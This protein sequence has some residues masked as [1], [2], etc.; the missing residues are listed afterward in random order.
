MD[1]VVRAACGAVRGVAR[2]GYCTF[3][4]IPYAAPLVGARR[5]RSPAPPQ[6]WDGVR[7]ARRFGS[8]VPQPVLWH[9]GDDPECLTVNV[10][11]PDVGTSGMPVMV[12]LH[13][14][15]CMGGTAATPDFDGAAF[16]AAGIVLV[17]VNYR[18]GYEG[19]GWVDDAPCNRGVL[20]QIAA[21]RWVRDNIAAFGGDPDAISLIGQSAGAS[22]I[23][24]LMAG[25]REPDLFRRAIAQSPGKIFVPVEEARAVSAMITSQLGVRPTADAL[26]ALPPEKIHA[27]QMAPVAVMA[28]EPG[29]WTLPNAP[30]SMII[31]HELFDAPPWFG[32]AAVGTSRELVC[33]FTTDEARMFTANVDLSGSDPVDTAR[34]CGL[35]AGAV[36]DYRSGNPGL[37][38][39]DLHALILSD[40]LFRLPALWCAE[41]AADAGTPTCLYE[42]AWQSPAR[43]GALRACHG[44]DVPFTF[45]TPR[46]PLA[47]DL[48]GPEV[49]PDFAELSAAMRNAFS[50]FATTGDPGWPRFDTTRR[51]HQIWR[52][53]PELGHDPLSTSRHIWR[54]GPAHDR[55][56]ADAS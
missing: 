38:D 24:G 17:T 3:F 7:D 13:G 20:D 16:A 4:A 39:D 8:S 31:D 14:G 12:W 22:S 52:T 50:A 19:F 37:T 44:L 21:L 11:T 43:D 53:P 26:A 9:P 35:D 51:V 5:F 46:G 28:A 55:S 49:P 1:V 30:Y 32:R 40:A 29:R 34:A 10:W 56:P 25:D 54:H 41:A 45:D 48:I 23:V 42:F 47:T 2:Q 6:R 15:A 36:R 33:G 27:V 18:V